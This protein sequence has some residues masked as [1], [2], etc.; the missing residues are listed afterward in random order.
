MITSNIIVYI[1]DA[2][3]IF[4]KW[5]IKIDNVPESMNVF[6]WYG[7]CHCY[8]IKSDQSH[9]NFEGA[10]RMLTAHTTRK[11]I[12][13]DF[14]IEFYRVHTTASSVIV[15]LEF[16]YIYLVVGN[17]TNTHTHW[18]IQIILMLSETPS[19]L[20]DHTMCSL[21]QFNHSLLSN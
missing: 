14:S 3:I 6:S 13:C 20:C 7:F 2:W 17:S 19:K 18:F 16:I 5:P 11:V 1:R 4:I 8:Q 9:R 10:Q 21:W 12:E 15:S